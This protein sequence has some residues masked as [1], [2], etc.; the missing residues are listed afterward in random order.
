MP[1]YLEDHA[2]L[3]EA[4]L[5]LFEAELRGA[6][7]PGGARARGQILERFADPDRGGFFS[8]ATDRE[9]LIARRKDL[10]DSPIPSGGRAPPRGCCAWPS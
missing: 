5:V 7:V 9:D 10:E 6:L 2:Y 4:M 1:A 3:L 8:T